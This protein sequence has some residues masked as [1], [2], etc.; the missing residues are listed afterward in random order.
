LIT[1]ILYLE[2][3]LANR[4]AEDFQRLGSH[5]SKAKLK[6]LGHFVYEYNSAVWQY[7]SK[8]RTPKNELHQWTLASFLA[9]AEKCMD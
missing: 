5:W 3:W 9:L 8:H 1:W 6:R 7:R 4:L 2:E